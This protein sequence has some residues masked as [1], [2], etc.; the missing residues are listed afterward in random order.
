MSFEWPSYCSG[1]K[2]K[3]LTSFIER[4]KLKIVD[5]DGCAGGVKSQEGYVMKKPWR[6]ATTSTQLV[7]SLSTK[8]CGRSH[9][10]EE[11]GGRNA[12]KS[13]FLSSTTR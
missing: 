7:S 3:E 9:Q 12:A 4:F 10:H 1:W 13:P 2:L 8:R 11:C 6:I 5:F